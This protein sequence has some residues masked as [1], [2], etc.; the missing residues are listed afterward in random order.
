AGIAVREDAGPGPTYDPPPEGNRFG[1]GFV[2][3][4][5]ANQLELSADLTGPGGYVK[6]IFPGVV[7]G[8]GGPHGDWAEAVRLAYER[9]LIPVVRFAPPWDDRRVR[10]QSDPGS[11]GLTYAQLAASYANVVRGLPLRE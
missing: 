7:P 6:L 4:G 3:P 1:I 8:M 11:D 9:D 5:D 10:N 2:G